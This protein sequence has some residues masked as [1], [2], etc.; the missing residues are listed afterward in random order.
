[1]LSLLPLQFLPPLDSFFTDALDALHP[2]TF[3]VELPAPKDTV[4]DGGRID[5][6]VGM[7]GDLTVQAKLFGGRVRVVAWWCGDSRAM[8]NSFNVVGEG[9]EESLA[10]A[11]RGGEDDCGY[12]LLC[13]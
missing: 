13:C 8:V 3:L 9:G 7:C 10:W 1:M 6:C 5:V 4:N 2:L 12:I 11:E